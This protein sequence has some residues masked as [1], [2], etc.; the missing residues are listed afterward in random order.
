MGSCSCSQGFC[1]WNFRAPPRIKRSGTNESCEFF[2]CLDEMEWP[3]GSDER[4]LEL[5]DPLKGKAEDKLRA[6]WDMLRSCPVEDA[7]YLS[8]KEMVTSV[9]TLDFRP[10]LDYQGDFHPPGTEKVYCSAGGVV[11]P[12]RLVLLPSAQEDFTGMFRGADFGLIRCSSVVEPS[13]HSKLHPVPGM[14]PMVAMKF[15]RD[16]VTSANL[17]LAHKK[18]GHGDPNFLAHAVSNHFTENLGP[19]A[20]LLSI[21]MKNSEFPT[22]SG[23][24]EFASIDQTGKHEK[25]PR[26]PYTI[27]FLAPEKIRRRRTNITKNLIEQFQDLVVGEVLFEVYVVPEPLDSVDFPRG[28]LGPASAVWR[29]GEVLLE[30]PFVSSVVG[31]KK[32]FFQHHLFE[33]DLEIRPDWRDKVDKMVG[34]PFYQE[35]IEHGDLWEMS[36]TKPKS[37]PSRSMQ[38]RGT[39]TISSTFAR[40]RNS[41]RCPFR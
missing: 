8:V 2:S 6:A 38:D 33:G 36:G 20:W 32:L 16:D 27:V 41:G 13:K 39:P 15:F 28:D 11:A 34:A 31:D 23:C 14:V 40:L 18:S 25:H 7:K 24:A 17:V 19:F 5:L 3:A 4:A 37:T 9:R 35:R 26:A 22:F 12:V 29:V 30:A 10:L 21:F 1:C